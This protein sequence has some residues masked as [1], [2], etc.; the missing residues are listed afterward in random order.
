MNEIEYE[1]GEELKA[2]GQAA[3]ENLRAILEANDADNV[4]QLARKAYKYT[5]CGASVGALLYAGEDNPG[6]WVWGEDLS[7]EGSFFTAL[8]VTSIVE[9]V[10]QTTTT[11]VIDLLDEKFETPKQAAEAYGAALIAVEDEATTIW[12]DTHGCPTCATHFGNVASNGIETC[13]GDDGITPVWD[14][15]PDCKG[16]GSII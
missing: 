1:R 5:D 14:K 13:K 7:V 9:G 3:Q 15:C 12:N 16:Y 11:H 10:D 6:S 8:S 2:M 4:G